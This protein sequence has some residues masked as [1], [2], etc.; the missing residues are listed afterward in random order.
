MTFKVNHEGWTCSLGVFPVSIKNEEFLALVTDTNI[1]EQ[2]RR[3]RKEVYIFC[4][5]ASIKCQIL[6]LLATCLSDG[7]IF[8][9]VERFD[10]TK[11]IKEKLLAIRRFFEKYPERIGKD[12]IKQVLHSCIYA[13][14]A[15]IRTTY[16]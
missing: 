10:Y 11:G 13:A 6:Q 12:V 15:L 5:K 8:F 3:I 4:H 2:A 16:R 14:D 1:Q 9:S 7:K